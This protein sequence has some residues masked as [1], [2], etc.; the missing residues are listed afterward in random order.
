[1]REFL[2]FL[3]E[4]IAERADSNIKFENSFVKTREKIKE[5]WDYLDCDKGGFLSATEMFNQVLC[6]IKDEKF[7][8]K[9]EI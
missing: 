7:R 6:F 4:K 9:F 2:F 8:N 3:I 1:M 5:L